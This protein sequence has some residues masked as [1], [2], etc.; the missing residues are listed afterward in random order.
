MFKVGD[1]IAQRYQLEQLLGQRGIGRQ[2]WRVVDCAPRSWGWG[3]L[4]SLEQIARL[5]ALRKNTTESRSVVKFLAFNEQMT[6]DEFKLFER[7][8]QILA[9]IDHPRI[10]HYQASFELAP[11]REIKG[12]WFAL[13]QDY[14]PGESLQSLLDRGQ[15]FLESDIYSIAT[16]ILEILRSCPTHRRS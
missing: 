5:T 6:W 10:P 1:L 4:R 12:H 16:Q 13:V 15:V 2:T 14:I 7:E 3:W 9:Q 11:D 8:A